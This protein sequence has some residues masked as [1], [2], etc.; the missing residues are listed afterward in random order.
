M[1]VQTQGGVRLFEG[2]VERP[3]LRRWLRIDSVFVVLS[4]LLV[5]LPASPLAAITGLERTWL[6]VAGV[7][8]LLYG[9]LLWWETGV[10]PLRIVGWAN[11]TVGYLWVAASVVLLVMGWLPLTSAGFWG[12]VALAVIVDLITSVQAYALVKRR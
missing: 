1:A 10:F 9:A 8:S 2:S 6:L 11:V 7:V 3:L 12:V 4:G 5:M